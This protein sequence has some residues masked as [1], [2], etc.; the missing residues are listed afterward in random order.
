[1]ESF[2]LGGL[3]AHFHNSFLNGRVKFLQLFKKFD[4]LKDEIICQ[5]NLILL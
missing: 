5:T 2:N 1:M 3:I 4:L